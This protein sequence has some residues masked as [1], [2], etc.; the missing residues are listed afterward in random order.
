MVVGGREGELGTTLTGTVSIFSTALGKVSHIH[1]IEEMVWVERDE[2]EE[3]EGGDDGG[4]ED[5]MFKFLKEDDSNWL[6]DV[7]NSVMILGAEDGVIL[8]DFDW[9][10]LDGGG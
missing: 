8:T 5:W 2:E 10:W 3:E 6:G 9:F 4:E 1:W 7:D